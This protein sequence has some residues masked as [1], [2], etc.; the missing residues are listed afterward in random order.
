MALEPGTRLGP[1]RL[2]GVLGAGGMGEVYR[3]RD[4]RLDRTVAIKILSALVASDQESR[5][6][7]EREARAIAALSH[8][9]ICTLYDV[10]EEAS[11][12]GSSPGSVQFLVMEYLEGA[13]LADVLRGK[14]L[15]L[16]HVLRIGI[17]CANALDRAHRT[18]IVH[19]D[20]KPANVMLTARGA[21]LLDFGLARTLGAAPVGGMSVGA[22]VSGPL[23]SQGT[24]LGTLHYM[25]PEQVEGKE[26]DA[27]SDIFSL[28]TI[29]YE[30]AMGKKAF[31]GNSAA[32]VMAAILE[33][34]PPPLSGRQPHA[35]PLFDH[36]VARCLAKD[37]TE[38]WQ[39][40]GDVMRELSWLEQ[41]GTQ[42]I[43]PITT[44]SPRRW[45][46]RTAWIVA[47]ALLTTIAVLATRTF[48][49]RRAAAPQEVR[50]D[51]ATPPTGD[52]FSLAIS[53][54]GQKVVFAAEADG[55]RK[56]W[57]RRLDSE[58]AQPLKGTDNGY[59]PFWSPDGKAIGFAASGQLKRIDLDSES[60]RK[61]AN[62][63]LFL[64]G[65][66]GSDNHIL[67]VPNTNSSV[68]RIAADVPGKPTVVTPIIVQGNQS[69]PHVLP[70]TDRFLFYE[71]SPQAPE[72]RGIYVS[73]ADGTAV[74]RLLDADSPAVYA[75]SGHLLFQLK[76]SLYAR[77][78]DAARGE[79]TGDPIK[80]TDQIINRDYA[81][82]PIVALSVAGTGRIVYRAG[83]RLVDGF[84]VG[85]FDRSGTRVVP[86]TTRLPVALNPALSPDG[87]R[88]AFF[89]GQI[90]LL[91]LASGRRTQFTFEQALQF[92]AVWSPDGSQIIF[93]S[94]RK[95][96]QDPYKKHASGA[97]GD[98]V[99][100]ET[101]EDKIPTD[102]SGD[103]KFLLYRNMDANNNFDI[104]GL[105]LADNTQFT[106]LA[107]EHDER[108]AQ[109]S[110]NGKWIAY[111]SNET[112]RF[113]ISV[114]PFR[115]PGT[116]GTNDE[117]WPITTD[118]G[119]QVRWRPDNGSELFYVGLDGRFMAVPIR[120][121][122]N[123][124]AI[125]AGA[126]VP[127]NAPPSPLLFGGG[128]ALPSYAVTKDGQRFLMTTLPLPPSTTPITVLLN[129]AAA[130]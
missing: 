36:I 54:D 55:V 6:R 92:V 61:L 3:A 105:S 129:W 48:V 80:V 43:E 94:N 96:P 68:H 119:A 49:T 29:L 60:V 2:E 116:D 79:V 120:E 5:Q 86:V 82:S 74:R 27:R 122:E 56:L 88:A 12:D 38:R 57:L 44:T 113:E 33:R 70:G 112:G 58:T 20:L 40:A 106:V 66:W 98:T 72:V 17:Q 45:I 41:T 34:E 110:P 114:R 75:P 85:W 7:F 76:G 22:T 37:P 14:R 25:S 19:R 89:I 64:G 16:D 63:P 46:E 47:L 100:L 95:G 77:S 23:T 65:T 78:F 35:P 32:G 15:P 26:A 101:A 109:L 50:L 42:T 31:E 102:W 53:P 9:H 71:T 13:T 59:L 108:D 30:M 1:Y 126:P 107:T 90:H 118:G 83:A 87:S 18:G 111:Q 104:R 81:G 24:I 73:N 125:K 103:G 130:R 123:G 127:L 93:S 10:G 121:T 39:S 97:G 21:V 28:G 4:V 84:Q 8:P 115:P 62:A 128:T 69:A 117:R 11:P 52:A 124:R 67:F 51:I 91:D 99:L